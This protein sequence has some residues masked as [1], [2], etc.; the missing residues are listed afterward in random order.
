MSQVHV[1]LTN[2]I[3]NDKQGRVGNRLNQKKKKKKKKKRGRGKKGGTKKK[4]KKKKKN[5][6]TLKY[7]LTDK[8]EQSYFCS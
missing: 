6:L 7:S 4:K 1:F 8:G 3:I 2:S 5:L